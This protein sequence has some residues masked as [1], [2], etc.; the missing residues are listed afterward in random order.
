MFNQKIVCVVGDITQ[1]KIGLSDSDY[2]RVT[3][4]TNIIIHSAADVSF[5]KPFQTILKINYFGSLEMLE[6]A[7]NCRNMLCFNQCTTVAAN[8]NL[9]P[10]KANIVIEERVYETEGKIEEAHK[11]VQEIMALPHEEAQR[12]ER[13]YMGQHAYNYSY[14]KQMVEK[15]LV[16]LHD[17]VPTLITRVG[18]LTNAMYEPYPG[19]IDSMQSY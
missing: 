3:A 1:P 7:R 14:T 5:D 4:E 15:S 17:T 18:V 13:K 11:T 16:H 8:N 10:S 12:K 2:Q 6:L 19:F 9:Y